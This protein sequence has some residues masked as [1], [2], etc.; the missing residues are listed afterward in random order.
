MIDLAI[1]TACATRPHNLRGIRESIVS[2]CLDRINTKWI[3][4][5]DNTPVVHFDDQWIECYSKHDNAS[6]F[7][8]AQRDY[9]VQFA[10]SGSWVWFLD[11][12]NVVHPNFANV[13]IENTCKSPDAKVIVVSQC[14]FVKSQLKTRL[15]AEPNN[16]CVEHIDIAQTIIIKEVAMQEKFM[17]TNK[18]QSDGFYVEWLYKRY[19]D[20]FVFDKRFACYYNALKLQ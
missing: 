16:C 18:Y 5:F 10:N 12:D 7:G 9:G 8:N 1:I 20:K 17:N 3:I 15:I 4:V 13:L 6:V 19:H 11:D 2:V 14:W